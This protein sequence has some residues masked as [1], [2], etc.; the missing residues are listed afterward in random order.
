MAIT[1]T[2]TEIKPF[3]NSMV[4]SALIRKVENTETETYYDKIK[5]EAEKVIYANSS[6]TS[7][8][9]LT[10]FIL[11]P[12]CYVVQYLALPL[13]SEISKEMQEFIND[14]YDFAIELLHRNPKINSETGEEEPLTDKSSSFTKQ[15]TGLYEI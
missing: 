7:N 8:D 14:K 4:Y 12:Y 2:L 15:L 3:I 5:I 6:Y 1:Y 10:A 9:D 13:L 11:L